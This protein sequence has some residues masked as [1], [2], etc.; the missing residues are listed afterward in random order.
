MKTILIT[1]VSSGLGRAVA[2]ACL[3][4]GHRVVGTLRD[5]AARQ[6]FEMLAP[7]CAFGRLLDVT[8]TAAIAPLV[9]RVEAE[10]GPLDVLVNNAGY[11]HRGVLEEVSLDELR[12][13]FEVN[14]FAPVALMQ[15]VLPRMRERGRGH[16]VNMT[17]MGAT[18]TFPGLG[19]YHGSKFALQ[20]LGDALAQEVAPFGIRVTAVQPGVYRSD[21]GGR[22]LSISERRIA[23]YAWVFDPARTAG[24]AWGHPSELGR[25]V[26]EAVDAEDPP[27]HLLVGPTAL[28]MV[29]ATLAAQSAEIDRWEH[30]SMANGEG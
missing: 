30:L 9:E 11:G 21:W 13:Q 3:A 8:D 25:V 7:G 1:G 5:E 14:V 20:G 26:A 29:R 19:A 6:A 2:I 22:S 10:H 17:S 12:R 23:G 24:L 18:V 4:R 15:A 27:L 16:I 28:R